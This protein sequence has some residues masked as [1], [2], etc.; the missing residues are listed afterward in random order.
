MTDHEFIKAFECCYLYDVMFCDKCPNKETC[1]EIDVA[2]SAL[3][4]LNRQQAEIEK[5]KQDL[6]IDL[7]GFASEYD[8]KIK[9]EARKEFA[10]KLLRK[11]TFMRDEETINGV[12]RVGDVYETLKEMG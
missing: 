3:D 6:T 5:M 7:E 1:G 4:L 12:V 2:E 10:N 8:E 11:A 9:S